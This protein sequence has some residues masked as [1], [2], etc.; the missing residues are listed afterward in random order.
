MAD[1]EIV[2]APEAPPEEEQDGP[3]PG[4]S[5]S[6]EDKKRLGDIIVRM[7]AAKEPD[8][9]IR[10]VVKHFT[11]KFGQSSNTVQRPSTADLLNTR[12]KPITEN[13]NPVQQIQE[14]MGTSF[15]QDPATI[16]RL[17]QYKG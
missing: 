12:E 8:D 7:Q 2:E 17:Q 4:P 3:G 5:F 11:E 1:E 14:R 9:N 13:V 10:A 6:A 15:N 16:A